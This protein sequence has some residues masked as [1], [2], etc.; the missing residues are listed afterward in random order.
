QN[1]T[2]DTLVFWD[3]FTKLSSIGGTSTLPDGNLSSSP[4]A[5]H[6][7][8]DNS[9]T[10]FGNRRFIDTYVYGDST[11]VTSAAIIGPN[12]TPV[13]RDYGDA[14]DTGAATPD[15]TNYTTT[16]SQGGPSHI[17]VPELSIGTAP[18]ADDGTQQNT[19][20][21]ADDASGSDEGAITFGALSLSDSDYILSN[22]AV[23][24][25]TS[26]PAYL[27]GWIDFDQ[28][29]TFDND[30][31]ATATV[32]AG[33]TTATL[34]WSGTA[35]NPIPADVVSGT[36][37][38]RFRYGSVSGLGP[39]GGTIDGEVEDYQ[40][41][42]D[43]PAPSLK[44]AKRMTALNRGLTGEQLFDTS[45]VDTGTAN[46]DDNAVN[47][48]GSPPVAVTIGSGTVESY[49]AGIVDGSSSGVSVSPGDEIEYTISFLS[50]GD[51]AA[52]DVLICDRIPANTTFVSDAFN[53]STHAGPGTGPRGILL[54]FNSVEVALTN[55]DDGDEIADTGANDG[56][57]GYY[58]PA[59]VDPSTAFP[60]ITVNC[61]GTND[62]GAIVVDVSDV[63]FATG[64]G[65]P[66]NSYGFVR[67]R[68][69]VD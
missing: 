39:T 22:I 5:R 7:W 6:N 4:A 50:D 11:I 15:I 33:E 62:N 8:G 67:F 59:G 25:T 37:Y 41:T 43:A 3:D 13:E 36:T 68:A 16:E 55:A 64:E 20:A 66:A 27:T 30:E 18:D 54:N 28:S 46:D 61:G 53:G 10:G 34:E 57:G 47:W 12:D 29:G 35:T 1:S 2:I 48:P 56:V 60:G 44:L 23:T 38:A 45:F 21:D 51:V 14:P 26:D 40:I 9:A 32:A 52:Q 69:V 42:I 58:F 65:T 49:I 24:N 19:D 17:I 63:P 31:L